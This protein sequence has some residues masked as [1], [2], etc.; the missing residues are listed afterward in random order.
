MVFSI[1]VPDPDL[2]IKGGDRSSRPLDKR[3]DGPPGPFPWIRHWLWTCAFRP[4]IQ[5]DIVN[6]LVGVDEKVDNFNYLFITCLDNKII[7]KIFI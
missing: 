2:E 7:I 3:G 5:W 6:L 1:S 4:K